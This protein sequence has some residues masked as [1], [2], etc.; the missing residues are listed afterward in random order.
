VIDEISEVVSRWKTFADEVGV[1]SR[2]R[3]E[4]GKTLIRL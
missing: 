2:L 4:I 1:E 3:D